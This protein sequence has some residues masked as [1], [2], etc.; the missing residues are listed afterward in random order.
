[1]DDERRLAFPE[2]GHEGWVGQSDGPFSLPVL[3]L[4]LR[5]LSVP[6]GKE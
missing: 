2:S 6:D 3:L 1:M 5:I 4:S